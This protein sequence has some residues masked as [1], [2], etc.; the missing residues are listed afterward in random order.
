V[1]K[2][3]RASDPVTRSALPGQCLSEECAEPPTRRTCR[4]SKLHEAEPRV[5]G[6]RDG[7]SRFA[8]LFPPCYDD[9]DQMPQD[10]HRQSG[11][12][13]ETRQTPSSARMAVVLETR[14]IMANDSR[15]SASTSGASPSIGQHGLLCNSQDALNMPS[16][17]S[18]RDFMRPNRCVRS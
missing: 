3:E 7:T 18:P 15:R 4:Q 2:K 8:P 14:A 9:P 17:T 5:L 12:P 11:L 1:L 6:V 10:K 16:L 13:V